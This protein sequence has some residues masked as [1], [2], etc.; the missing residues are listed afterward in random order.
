MLDKIEIAEP[1][2][3]NGVSTQLAI[4]QK[5]GGDDVSLNDQ[6]KEEIIYNASK[7][8]GE[9]LTALGCDWENDPNSANTPTRVAKA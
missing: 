2:F 5:L 3:A 7:A 4:K 6:E 9:F 1:G 8:F